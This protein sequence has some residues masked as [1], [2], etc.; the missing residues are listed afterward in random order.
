MYTFSKRKNA[1][2]LTFKVVSN[3][4]SELVHLRDSLPNIFMI[5]IWF[6]K[7]VT[8]HNGKIKKI[9][10]ITNVNEIDLFLC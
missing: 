7:N 10:G 1:Q 2:S 3:N 5:E 8:K 6:E 9:Y 4:G